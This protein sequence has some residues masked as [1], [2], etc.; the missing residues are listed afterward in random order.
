[1][2]FFDTIDK[3]HSIRTYSDR[4]IEFEKLQKLLETINSAPSAGDLQAYDVVLVKDKKKKAALTEA[5]W[6]QD[7]ISEA[8]VVFVFC[9]NAKLSEGKYG[10]R[11]N[12]L[13][14]I[15]DATIACTF[16]HLSAVA[17]GLSS[18]WVG[19]FD[20][21]KVRKIIRAPAKA[22]PVAILPVGY[23]NESPEPRPRRELS[24]II[25]SEYY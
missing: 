22:L 23:P 13:Y 12:E 19:A 16:A 9:A 25:K 18:C 5:A 4:A 14:S 7:F 20:E 11:G 6:N 17:L 15:Q 1:M 10:S 8:P 2:E 3:R 24:D 21:T